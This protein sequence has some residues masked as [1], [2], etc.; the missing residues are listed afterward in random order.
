MIE[1][2]VFLYT[3][4]DQR[5]AVPDGCEF[6]LLISKTVLRPDRENY[7]SLFLMNKIALAA[8]LIYS[9]WH[10]P[11]QRATPR[12]RVLKTS[13]WVKYAEES[14][15]DVHFYDAS[16]VEEDRYGTSSLEWRPLQ[17]VRHG[18]VQLSK[19]CWKSTAPSGRREV[20]QSTF[21]SDK[22]WKE[23]AMMTDTTKKR[24]RPIAAGSATE[25]LS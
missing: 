2:I 1:R 11:S 24:K 17:N 5:I 18:C 14:N 8:F 21:F 23:P 22:H 3:I 20:L 19:P 9:T 16:R 25:R 13:E 4:L 12:P 6:V 15:G 10:R 7:R